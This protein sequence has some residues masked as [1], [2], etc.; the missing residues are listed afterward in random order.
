MVSSSLDVELPKK[1]EFT[2]KW[3]SVVYDN[4]FGS[5]EI[6][7]CYVLVPLTEIGALETFMMNALSEQST[8]QRSV[9]LQA[10]EFVTN[11]SSE[12]YLRERR[13]KIKAELGVSLSVFSP[14]RIFTTMKELL[15]SVQ[16][17]EFDTTNAQFNILKE[18]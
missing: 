17:S 11:F 7:L 13:E 4:A 3:V 14:D 15:D 8:E 10:K 5:T 16:W 18:L 1:V 12:K 2:N 6:R 9:I